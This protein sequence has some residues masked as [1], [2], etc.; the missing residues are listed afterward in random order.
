MYIIQRDLAVLLATETE[1][2][3]LPMFTDG[4]GVAAIIAE[5]L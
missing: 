4:L 2:I 5:A 3:Y 1:N